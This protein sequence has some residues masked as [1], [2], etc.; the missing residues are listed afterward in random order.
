MARRLLTHGLVVARWVIAL[1]ILFS[2][3]PVGRAQT[4]LAPFDCARAG[5]PPDTPAS[6]ATCGWATLPEDANEPDSARTV[7]IAVAVAHAAASQPSPDPIV[8]LQGGPG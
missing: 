8:F 6:V 7:L 5:F 1:A 4:P 2:V 3:M